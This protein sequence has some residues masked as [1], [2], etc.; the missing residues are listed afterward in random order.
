MNIV[1]SNTT[2]DSVPDR[3]KIGM[4]VIRGNSILSLKNNDAATL[5]VKQMLA[6]PPAVRWHAHLCCEL[7]VSIFT[8]L[9]HRATSHSHVQTARLFRRTELLST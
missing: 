1:L 9:C 8:L 6:A 3:P 5:S 2:D 7:S 4:V